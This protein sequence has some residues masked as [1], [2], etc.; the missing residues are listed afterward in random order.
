LWHLKFLVYKSYISEKMFIVVIV[1]KFSP[2]SIKASS[3]R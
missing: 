2:T 3:Y 1:K